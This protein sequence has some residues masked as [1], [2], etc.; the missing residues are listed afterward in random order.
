MSTTKFFYC[1]KIFYWYQT[2]FDRIFAAFKFQYRK[3]RLDFLY[4]KKSMISCEGIPRQEIFSGNRFGTN[5][6]ILSSC[7]YR[8]LDESR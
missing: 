4:G 8:I 6:K 5:K 7:V 2:G 1:I 3:C